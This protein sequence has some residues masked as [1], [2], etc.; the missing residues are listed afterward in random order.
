MVGKRKGKGKKRKG[1]EHQIRSHEITYIQATVIGT[2]FKNTV[3]EELINKTS[4]GNL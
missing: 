3:K 1:C 2:F 4:G